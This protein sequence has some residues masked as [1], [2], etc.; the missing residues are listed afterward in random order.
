M[1]RAFI[2]LLIIPVFAFTQ[3]T[4]E[5]DFIAPIYDGVAAVK[6]DNA[7]GFINDKGVII[8]N[9][10][11]DLV[12]TKTNDGNYPIFKNDRC[13]IVEKREGITYFGYIDKTGETVIEPKFLNAF[14]FNDNHAIVLKLITEVIGINEVLKK[15]VVYHKYFEVII[16]LDGH[17]KEYLNPKGVPVVLDK[18]FL[19]EPPKITSRF[20][21]KN[22]IAIMNEHKKWVVKS[23]NF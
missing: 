1:K 10:R 16:N 5:L 7:W 22:I 14:N 19:K 4:E 15:R 6:K 8:I 21:S 12:L 18:K 9:F 2:I 23:V 17:I 11:D 20:I 3:T 13:L